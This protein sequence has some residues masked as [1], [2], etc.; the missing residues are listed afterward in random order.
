M[1]KKTYFV[2]I[3]KQNKISGLDQKTLFYHKPFFETKRE[4]VDNIYATAGEGWQIVEIK[5]LK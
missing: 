4:M 5:C 3:K 2:I 1:F